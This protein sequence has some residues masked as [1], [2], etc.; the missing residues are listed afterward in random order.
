MQTT[1]N[2]VRLVEVSFDTHAHTRLPV[3]LCSRPLSLGL[4]HVHKTVLR[5]I[6]RGLFCHQGTIGSHIGLA[7]YGSDDLAH[8]RL[9]GTSAH[10]YMRW[11]G[12]TPY[13]WFRLVAIGQLLPGESLEG[14]SF[15][16]TERWNN[17]MR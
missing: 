16:F 17:K 14:V 3:L 6:V 12:G 8:W 7:L 15:E 1:D 13:K 2:G 10:Q 5:T 9:I 11:H 4:R